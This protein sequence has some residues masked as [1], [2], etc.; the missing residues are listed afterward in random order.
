MIMRLCTS[1]V[2]I[3]ATA[4]AAPAA[5]ACSAF[6]VAD[7]NVVLFGNNED[8]WNPLI[9][10]WVIPG[11]DGEYG[12]VCFGYDNYYCQGGMNEKGLVFDGFATESNPVTK[13]LE[14]PRL[15]GNMIDEAL[16]RC[17]TVDEVLELFDRYNLAWMERCMLMFADRTGAAAIIEGDEV[18]RKVGKFQIVTNFY[19]S[20]YKFDEY[21]C[22]RYRTMNR[23]LSEADQ[24]SVGLC[25][26]ALDAVHGEGRSSTLYSNVY[27][28]TKGTVNLYFFHDFAHPLVIDLAAELKK[29]E[30]YVDIPSLFPARPDWEKY[31]RKQLASMEER[32][33]K[34]KIVK[35]E[36]DVLAKYAGTYKADEGVGTG[37]L[38]KFWVRDGK[39][40]GNSGHHPD[41]EMCPMSPTDF[42]HPIYER[43]Y[44]LSFVSEGD[45]PAS[46]VIIRVGGQTFHCARVE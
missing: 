23:L 25:E 7:E 34:R 1:A 46:A 31:E 42:F 41:E 32:I 12:R 30:H 40:F 13:S 29:G 8:Y 19:Q 21:P 38:L 5:H 37:A 22:W 6:L 10:M 36:P 14:K 4:L 16:S 2:A 44:D 3:A 39:L 15:V 24:F 17:A 20:Q 11:G 27:D 9:K 35:V 45:Q 28:L 18:L 43:D 26:R 33:A